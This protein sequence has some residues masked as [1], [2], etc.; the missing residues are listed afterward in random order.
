MGRKRNNERADAMRYL[1][2][3]GASL[4][5]VADAFRCTR[6]SV[7][8]MFRRRGWAMRTITP[9][10]AVDW[11]GYRY[12]MRNMGYLG[13][14]TGERTLL[15]RDVWESA[16]GA[17]PQGWDIHHIDGCKTNNDLANLQLLS[18]SAHAALHAMK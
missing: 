7:Y 17:I 6:Q 9:L 10:P 13:R 1:Y 8:V 4:S 5:Q 2:E 11:G 18:K 14:T 12:T 3:T 16:N 15:H